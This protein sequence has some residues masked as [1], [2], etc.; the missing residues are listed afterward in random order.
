MSGLRPSV[1]EAKQ[2][3]AQGHEQLKR[4]HQEGSPG[5]ELSAA[6]ADLRDEV[7]LN[8]HR[9]A[10]RD[11]GLGETDALQGQ[12]ALVAHGGYGRRDLAP[13][14]DVD[15]MVLH[16][17]TRRDQLGPLAERLLCDVFD[18]GMVL[19]HS[20]RT[21]EEACR[22][23]CQDATICS[24]LI[25]SRLLAGSEPLFQR[26]REMFHR[27]VRGRESS[28]LPA[29]EAARDEE[30]HKFGETT[31]LLEPN[32]KRS[33]GGLRDLQLLRWIGMIRYGTPEPAELHARGF[34]SEEDLLALR[35]AIE[36][37]LLLRNEMHFH[38]EHSADVLARVEQVRIAQL[39]G[40]EASA[41]MLPVELFMR[42][43]FRHT[44]QVSHVVSRFLQKAKSRHQDTFWTIVFGH[45]VHEGYFVGPG[46]IMAGR[47]ATER[48]RGNLGA[49]V[50][51]VDL[52]NLYNTQISPQTWDVVRREAGRLSASEP[53]SADA[54]RHFLSLLERP[55][56][57]GEMLRAL[58]EVGVLE[59]IIPEFHH[60][61]GLLQFNQYHKYTVDEHSFRAVERATE[62][63]S[64]P[65]PLGRVYRSITHKR[66]LHLALLIHDLGKGYPDDHS[67]LGQRI[68]HKTAGRLG[69]EADETAALEFLVRKHLWMNHLAFRRDT[70]DEQLVVKFAVEVG[71]PEMLQMLFV[72]TA[73]DVGA[74]GP[75]TWTSWKAEVLTDLYHRAMQHLAGESLGTRREE[76][77]ESRREM[78]RTWLGPDARQEW[79]A[80]QV[81][82]APPAYLNT[83][84]PHQIA[85]DLRLLSRLKSGDVSAHGHYQP[86]TNTVQF[87]IGTSEDV[88]PG[89]FHRL[90][91]ALSSQGLEIL[92]A[93]INTLPDRLVLDRF[94][95]YD[96]D[97]AGQPPADRLE[98]I[99]QKLVESLK[100]EG[101]TP[102]FRRVWKMGGSKRPTAAV[103]QTRVQIDNATS[104]RYTIIDV[105]TLDRR[106]LLYTITRTLFELGCS[107]WRAKIGTYLDQVVD[108]FY[109]TDQAGKKLEDPGWLHQV[110]QRLLEVIVELEKEA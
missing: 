76:W 107:V 44:D 83:T 69:L 45:R 87:T 40:Y 90:T 91:G 63:A 75:D 53:V 28:L 21:I 65:G 24:S 103:V 94:W 66:T 26:F 7:L 99:N 10:L 71:T 58:H 42:D 101:K 32:L 6:I 93:Q 92:S 70:G 9:A 79:F 30:R 109:V 49:I 55:S 68:A 96:P 81:D 85:A 34:L 95:V 31:H 22:L 51:L 100:S 104:D 86:D 59:R 29:V 16:A 52:A 46:R 77:L 43:Y 102:T 18:A 14:S 35:A 73:A 89:I 2:R 23:A 78:V 8:L 67:E 25:E 84:D 11:L 39:L 54:L 82:A 41:G 20:V 17:G 74:V 15:V 50:Q 97:F 61:R 80:R 57:L 62:L 108:V 56:R 98:R 105:F 19:G 12:I 33:R 27:R 47:Q 72:L 64:D 88:A 5:V 3:L 13:Y 1:Q 36:F 4:R 106:G 60:A 48:L 110:R 38:A 37:L